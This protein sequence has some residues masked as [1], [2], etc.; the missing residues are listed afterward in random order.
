MSDER[1]PTAEPVCGGSCGSLGWTVER[2]GRV[3]HKHGCP[4]RADPFCQTHPADTVLGCR[5]N[6]TPTAEPVTAL[7]ADIRA[8][9]GNHDLGASALAEALIERGWSQR[10]S[11]AEVERLREALFPLLG[12]GRQMCRMCGTAWTLG[13]EPFHDNKAWAGG[14]PVAPFIA[15]AALAEPDHDP[16]HWLGPIGRALAPE[17]ERQLE[18]MA[19][20][21]KTAEPD[22]DDSE[23]WCNDDT[24]DHAPG[25]CPNFID[26]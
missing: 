18:R 10:S 20:V 13:D 22:H 5:P 12:D 3:T 7:A 15:R 2:Y 25:E 4:R 9:D 11:T 8:V 14:C 19:I 16:R 21:K 24:H 23:D 17:V 6:T 26:H 1:T